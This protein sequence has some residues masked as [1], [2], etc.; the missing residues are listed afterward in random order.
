MSNRL[1]SDARLLLW[2]SSGVFVII[3]IAAFLAPARGD[4]DPVPST[5]NTGSA[6]ARAAYLL[7]AQLGYKTSRWEQPAAQLSR[8][9]AARTTLI[10]ADAYLAGSH[11]MDLRGEQRGVADF[12]R[13]GGRVLATGASSAL[14]LPSSG[15]KPSNQVFTGLCYT[16][17]QSLSAMGRAGKVAMPVPVQW[18]GKD[19]QVDQACGGDAVV[20]HYSVGAGEAVWWSSAAPL[21]NRG[22]HQDAG[23]RLLLAS[24]GAPGRAVLFD[25]YIHGERKS[26]FATVKGTPVAAIFWQL[27][28]MAL[29]LIL[30]FSRRNGPVRALVTAPRTSPLEFAESMGALYGKAGAT[31]VAVGAAGR[32]LMEFL[33]SEGGIPRQTLNSGPD[34]IAAAVA[35]RFAYAGHGFEDD[36]KAAR[37][38][39]SAKLSAKSALALVRRLDGHIAALRARIR[40]RIITG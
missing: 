30:S 8:V 35:A 2:V 10:L 19:A 36:L 28:L 3:L 33:H 1:S 13:R 6:G 32:R 4:Y 40:T 11:L 24:V 29:L 14:L 38:A 27:A 18:T 9:D 39:G 16:T 25:E 5:W 23:L 34:A 22:L 17:P 7:L 26:I 21:S 12:L 37:E 31:D 15:V 20:V